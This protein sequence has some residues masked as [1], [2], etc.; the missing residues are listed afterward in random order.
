[1]E[2]VFPSTSRPRRAARRNP[3]ADN[4]GPLQVSH[5]GLSGAIGASLW[6]TLPDGLQD[7]LHHQWTLASAYWHPICPECKFLLTAILG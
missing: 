2:S 6:P 1:M 3:H 4:T 7:G 5:A